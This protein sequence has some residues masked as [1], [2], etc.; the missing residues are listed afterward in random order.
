MVKKN[1]AHKY[2]DKERRKNKAKNQNVNGKFGQRI[3]GTFW[4]NP[5]FLW[6]W[7]HIKKSKILKTWVTIYTYIHYL[8]CMLKKLG[9]QFLCWGVAEMEGL[10]HNLNSNVHRNR[11]EWVGWRHSAGERRSSLI[12][13]TS[14]VSG[15][16]VTCRQI[17]PLG[18]CTYT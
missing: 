14:R 16:W 7:N 8:L 3:Y 1:Y 2:L 5:T 12:F 15:F 18:N 11:R 13:W 4:T 10:E 9:H 6:S 17:Y